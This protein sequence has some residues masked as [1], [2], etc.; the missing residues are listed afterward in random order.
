MT[1]KNPAPGE[2]QSSPQLVEMEAELAELLA[3]IDADLAQRA[4]IAH[5]LRGKRKRLAE[6]RKELAA[7]HQALDTRRRFWNAV[8]GSS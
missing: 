1:T 5:W 2:P 8:E 4:S 6:L 3:A 7:E